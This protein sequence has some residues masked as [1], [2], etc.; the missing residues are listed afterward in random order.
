MDYINWFKLNLKATPVENKLIL[1][2]KPD[3]NL[4]WKCRIALV[5]KE[6]DDIRNSPK[7]LM[8]IPDMPET[9]AEI[10]IDTLIDL[11][12]THWTYFNEPKS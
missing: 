9:R 8:T 7:L 2:Y 4:A 11:G 1:L 5:T 3:V 10:Y 12:Y 6:W